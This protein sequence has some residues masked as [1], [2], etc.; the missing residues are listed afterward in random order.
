M[1]AYP[2][3]QV[4]N[5]ALVGHSGSGKTTLTEALL[6][7]AGVL[8][9]PGRVEDGTTVSDHDAEE[10]RRG[11]SLSLTL[12]PIELRTR[13][14]GGRETTLKVNVIDTPGYAD[15]VGEVHAA[16]S[17]AD[18]AVFVVS[19]VEGVEVQ[20]EEIW[21][22]AARLGLP[23]MI[24]VNKLDRERADFDR[25]LD[26]LR[27]TFGAGIAPLELPIGTESEF[28]GVADLLTDTAY[29]YGSGVG[30][31]GEIP[32]EM[33]EREHEV[34]D[35]LIEGIVVG[36]D[37]LLERYLDGDVPSFTELEA[38]LA[39][40]VAAGSVF[41]VVCGAASGPVA[42]DRLADFIGEIAPS[43]LDR[44]PPEVEA[45]DT[46]T[47]IA[48]DPDGDPLA[49][50]FRTIADPY[51]GHVSLFRVLSGTIRPDDHLVNSRTGTDERLHSLFTLRGREQV[52]VDAV[53]AGDIGAVA[54]LSGTATGDTLAPRHLPVR[55][56]LLGM[57]DPLLSR[58]IVPR[59]QADE[60]KLVTALHRIVEED[61]S[62]RVERDD[63][64]HQTLLHA[65]GETH[66]AVTLERLARRFGVEVDTEDVRIAYRETICATAEG[67]GRHKKQ[68]GGHGQF[69]IARIRVEPLPRGAGFEFV[70]A[71]VGGAI[72]KNLIPAVAKG[73]EEAMA[74]GGLHGHPVVDVRVT[75]LDGK[76]HPVD[77]SEAS[78]KVA[79]SLAFRDALTRAGTE[80]LEPVSLVT[81]VV[82][83]TLLGEVLGDL[84]A[85]RGRVLGTEASGNRQVVSAHVPASE[86]AHYATDLRSLTGGRA[87]FFARH[88]HHD[89]LPAHLAAQTELV[90]T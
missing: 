86:L 71:V 14:P 82:P 76:H 56:P 52:P 28:C 50:V 45:G 77:S 38:V 29:F 57:P 35:A 61:P 47:A 37:D 70:D 25:T 69:G 89:V 44:P 16:L 80:V 66:I 72:P 51:V 33:E 84:N 65:L 88:D 67:E 68:S 55:V 53:A 74:S 13:V 36:D 10:V 64:T 6:H 43:P 63:E 73:A 87:R 85:R 4:R 41:P 23:R 30:V 21:E 17:A 78:F 5:V 27:E 40:G 75:C 18:L 46:T 24:F 20:T 54:K 22:L 48:P 34:H 8:T 59:N 32:E 58:G 31:S 2:P 42:V 19:A 90:R 9:R 26:Q 15:F 81:V 39:K 49:V 1:Q 83:A 7:H 12:A 79:G 11:I 3:A 60:D 62:L